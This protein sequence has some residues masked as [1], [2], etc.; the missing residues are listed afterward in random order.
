MIVETVL[1][2]AGGTERHG[3][4]VPAQASRYRHLLLFRFMTF[5]L[6]GAA[7]V[8][9]AYL[10]GWV[11]LVYES[12]LTHLTFVITAL[13]LSGFGICVLKIVRASRELNGALEF[14]PRS[15]SFA[16][17]YVAEVRERSPESRALLASA[18]KMKLI[19]RI[20]AVRSVANT[21]VFLGLIGTV[22]GFIIALSGVNP[23]V[24]SDISAVGPIVS[25]LIQGMSVALYTTLIGAILNIWLMVNYRVLASGT[26]NLLTALIELGE[27]HART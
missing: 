14:D 27:K 7:L 10:Q 6:V 13:F 3:R 9:A 21:L 23:E 16:A 1:H 24:V 12:D 17:R 11:T 26:V 22:I 25:N 2:P 15:D 19:E 5:N 8:A 20:T 4:F 18:L